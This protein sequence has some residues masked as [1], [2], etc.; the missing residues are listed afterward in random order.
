MKNSILTI[1]SFIIFSSCCGKVCYTVSY[2]GNL[3]EER[4][5]KGDKLE[6]I[7][8]FNLSDSKD[9][10]VYDGQIQFFHYHKQKYIPN[11]SFPFNNYY[12]ADF[13]RS[14]RQNMIYRMIKSQILLENV[15]WSL[16]TLDNEVDLDTI[17]KKIILDDSSSFIFE[18]RNINTQCQLYGPFQTYNSEKLNY[19]KVVIRD[20]YLM[21]LFLKGEETDIIVFFEYTNGIISKEKINFYDSGEK[22][23]RYYEEYDYNR[24]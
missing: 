6:S 5:Y 22:E 14:L 4:Y 18:Y 1:I 11:S 13:D 10:I 23:C 9:S 16:A 2:N 19:V 20:G 17:Q 3:I 7:T 12:Y 21:K 8:A 15:L 24:K